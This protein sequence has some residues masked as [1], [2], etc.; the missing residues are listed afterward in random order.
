[1]KR[2]LIEHVSRSNAIVVILRLAL[3]L[4]IKTPELLAMLVL[5]LIHGHRQHKPRQ[6]F[7]HLSQ[8]QPAVRPGPYGVD[9]RTCA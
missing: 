8:F 7:R 6:V 1:M 5:F 4:F 2:M 3:I 9:Q